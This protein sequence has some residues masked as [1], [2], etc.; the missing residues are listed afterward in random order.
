MRRPEI[1]VNYYR[2]WNLNPHWRYRPEDFKSSVDHDVNPIENKGLDRIN[3]RF[4]QR[5][6]TDTCKT[7]P[8]LLSVIDAWP[9]LS[10]A[11]RA[12]IAAMVKAAS[13]TEA[14]K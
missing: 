6:P 5:V 8:E 10:K 11:V 13:A 9:T 7:D 14:R 1:D 2:R 3:K 12:G 4:A